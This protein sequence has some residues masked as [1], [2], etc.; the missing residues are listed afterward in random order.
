MEIRILYS[1]LTICA[2]FHYRYLLPSLMNWRAGS[3]LENRICIYNLS[4]F[5]KETNM[6]WILMI[7]ESEN[8]D[9]NEFVYIWILVDMS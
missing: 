3:I 2:K 5:S 8:P 7:R 4:M 6:F 9:Q 1:S